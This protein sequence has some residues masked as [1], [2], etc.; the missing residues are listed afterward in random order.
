VYNGVEVM[1]RGTS[2]NLILAIVGIGLLTTI[3]PMSELHTCRLAAKVHNCSHSPSCE[4]GGAVWRPLVGP[5][6]DCDDEHC[7][8]CQLSRPIQSPPAI[9]RPTAEIPVCFPCPPT[10]CSPPARLCEH[11]LRS[12]APPA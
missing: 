3:G 11:P 4:C 7:V 1:R 5:C 6:A 9:W 2:A 8:A 12:R 10:P